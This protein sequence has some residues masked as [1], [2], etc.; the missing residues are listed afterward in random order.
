LAQLFFYFRFDVYGRILFR[1]L[2]VV[3]TVAAP[4]FPSV[5]YRGARPQLKHYKEKSFCLL[6]IVTNKRSFIAQKS[7]QI[8]IS[9]IPVYSNGKV[10]LVNAKITWQRKILCED[11]ET[12]RRFLTFA[13]FESSSLAFLKLHFVGKQISRKDEFISFKPCPSDVDHWI[14]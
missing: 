3:A 7:T 12:R 2:W 9:I 4:A 5:C 11:K 13:Q 8:I 10:D 1:K 14:N 6:Y